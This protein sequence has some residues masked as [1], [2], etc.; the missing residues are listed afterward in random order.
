MSKLIPTIALSCLFSMGC[1]TLSP[2]NQVTSSSN[3]S[4]ETTPAKGQ[5]YSQIYVTVPDTVQLGT[6]FDVTFRLA[7]R[8]GNTVRQDDLIQVSANKLGIVF[9]SDS[10]VSIKDGIGKVRVE[11]SSWFG[12]GLQISARSKGGDGEGVIFGMSKRIVISPAESAT[13]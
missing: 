1:A 11:S 9:S 8:E 6:R 7:D 13:C 3:E 10:N 2:S 5:T 4:P 12:E